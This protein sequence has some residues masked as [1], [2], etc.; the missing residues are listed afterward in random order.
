M[1]VAKNVAITAS[2]YAIAQAIATTPK[3]NEVYGLLAQASACPGIN[4]ADLNFPFYDMGTIQSLWD[5]A[6]DDMDAGSDDLGAGQ[7][8]ESAGNQARL[9][10]DCGTATVKFYDARMDYQKAKLHYNNAYNKRV[11]VE[12]SLA[13]L[14]LRLL[15]LLDQ[16][17]CGA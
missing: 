13:E 2:N 6:N 7:I 9:N 16:G 4:S 12:K 1:A 17:G 15:L 10:G 5:E 11:G 3:M 14:K 8:D